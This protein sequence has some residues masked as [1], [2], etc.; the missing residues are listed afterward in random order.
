[1]MLTIE[2]KLRLT[3]VLLSY[4]QPSRP[5]FVSVM[6]CRDLIGNILQFLEPRDRYNMLFVSKRLIV[7]KDI[8]HSSH[9]NNML[10]DN[11]NRFLPRD[12]HHLEA[13]QKY[14]KFPFLRRQESEL[15]GGVL[16]LNIRQA[17][18]IPELQL[19]PSPAIS[20]YLRNPFCFYFLLKG[21]VISAITSL[22]GNAIFSLRGKAV[23]SYQG[24]GLASLA[25]AGVL[26][27]ALNLSCHLQGILCQREYANSGNSLLRKKERD[28]FKVKCDAYFYSMFRLSCA[29]FSLTLGELV[30]GKIKSVDL[31][32]ALLIQL[33]G[34]ATALSPVLIVTVAVKLKHAVINYLLDT[35]RY[36][37]KEMVALEDQEAKVVKEDGG[38]VLVELGNNTSGL[39][40][41]ALSESEEVGVSA[42]ELQQ[43]SL[44]FKSLNS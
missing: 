12:F 38:L 32:S 19:F 18:P 6:G 3:Q 13:H 35:S 37:Q 16:F 17:L 11:P 33:C 26:Y 20:R 36:L 2:Q 25:G 7:L 41:R 5:D 43:S 8:L 24:I 23:D 9:W 4:L 31:V 27:L 40:A 42:C 10:V 1:M 28:S 14:F 44:S 21:L 22:L 39:F 29:V 30:T 15:A 34:V